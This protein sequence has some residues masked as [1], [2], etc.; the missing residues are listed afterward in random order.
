MHTQDERCSPVEP[1][2]QVEIAADVLPRPAGA[3]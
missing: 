1:D 2:V 3:T